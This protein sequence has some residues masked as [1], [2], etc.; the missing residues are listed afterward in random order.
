MPGNHCPAGAAT[1]AGFILGCEPASLSIVSKP[2]ILNV[3]LRACVP[4]RC[5]KMWFRTCKIPGVRITSAKSANQSTAQAQPASPATGGRSFLDML[6]QASAQTTMPSIAAAAANTP[7]T[8]VLP[9]NGKS[10]SESGASTTPV[11]P[12]PDKAQP[13][14]AAGGTGNVPPQVLVSATVPEALPLQPA[15]PASAKGEGNRA[16]TPE[17][18]K[19][20]QPASATIPVVAQSALAVPQAVVASPLLL[21]P[22]D[23]SPLHTLQPKP[24]ASTIQS[25]G[26]TGNLPDGNAAANSIA[27]PAGNAAAQSLIRAANAS[28]ANAAVQSADAPSAQRGNHGKTQPD[29]SQSAGNSDPSTGNPLIDKNRAPQSNAG[30]NPPATQPASPQAPGQQQTIPNT[31]QKV[32]ALS[33]VPTEGSAN[34]APNPGEASKIQRTNGTIQPADLKSSPAAAVVKG[35]ESKITLG[36]SDAQVQG[37]S[38]DNQAGQ[39][40]DTH[41]AQ[42]QPA[43]DAAKQAAPAPS[44]QAATVQA[45]AHT[46]AV[47]TSHA[48]PLSQPSRP[49]APTV[50]QQAP[51]APWTPTVSTASLIQKMGETEM[52][53]AVNSTDYGPISIRTSLSQQQMMTQITVDHGE[54]G[55]ALT[56]HLP[57]METRLGNELGVRA[58]VQVHQAS[59]SFSAGGGNAQ[60]G[61]RQS[62]AAA[63]AQI[64]GVPAFS[65]SNDA[66]HHFSAIAAGEG[67]LD[68]QA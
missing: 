38:S 7:F 54:L 12:A 11:P 29:S 52:R 28:P 32:I 5:A 3:Q 13:Q 24:N 16:A 19:P 10:D 51:E 59:M 14:A 37:A 67:R 4:L 23:P 22:P 25:V 34:G 6:T 18:K 49:S 61:G 17:P 60:Q 46:G 68:I 65:E 9:P 56:A 42:S 62:H 27:L 58:V 8:A 44:A 39:R 20:A 40:P 53:V 35:K 57:A 21:A 47:A 64:G 66:A 48:E 31:T 45:T 33:I 1:V 43:A 41:L 55:K 30:G 15:Q 63:P 36:A 50:P 26:Q 2:F